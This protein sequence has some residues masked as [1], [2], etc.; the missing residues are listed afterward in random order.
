MYYS[1]AKVIQKR[2]IQENNNHKIKKR[3][4][5]V[6]PFHKHFLTLHPEKQEHIAGIIRNFDNERRVGILYFLLCRKQ[7]LPY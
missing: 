6:W 7:A 3:T 5:K 1:V 2:H 4:P